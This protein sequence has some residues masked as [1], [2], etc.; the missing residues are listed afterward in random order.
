M[1]WLGVRARLWPFFL[2]YMEQQAIIAAIQELI[3]SG[4]L[5]NLDQPGVQTLM[6]YALLILVAI[7]S[8]RVIVINGWMKC[9][10][11]RFFS[12]E[13]AKV[14]HLADLNEKVVVVQK[15]IDEEHDKLSDV[16]HLLHARREG[17]L[18]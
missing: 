3:K 18:T 5:K 13:E 11:E 15:L 10:L 4:A 16:L 14:K 2:I 6:I 8:F 7:F 9:G 1:V 12:L 17:D